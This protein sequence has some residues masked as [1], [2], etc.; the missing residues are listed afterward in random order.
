MEGNSVKTSST[1]WSQVYLCVALTTMA[2]LLLELSLTRIFS[3]IFYYHFAFLAISIAMF[4]LGLGGVFSYVVAGWKIPLFARLGR[5]SAVNSLLTVLAL[6]VIVSRGD[7]LT[8]WDFGLVYVATALP[9]FISGAIVSLAISETIENV[10]RVYFFD[11]LGAAGGCLLLIPL[12]HVFK[13]PSAVIGAA[14]VFAVAAAIWHSMAGSTIGRIAS[15][16]LALV[17]V[18]FFTLNQRRAILGITHAKGQTL[19]NEFF[20]KWNT[21]SRIAIVHLPKEGRDRIVIDADAATD[22]ANKDLDHLSPD[23]VHELLDAG[24]GLP[25]SIRPAAKTLIIGPGGGWDVT[26]ALASGSRDVT[27]VEINPIIAETIMQEKFPHLSRNL[28]K[29]PGVHV[30]VEDGRSF[31]RRSRDRY[32]VLQATLVDTWASTAA[33]AFA[34]SENNL[35][36][37][38]AFRDYLS[39]LTDD[40][41]VTVT[42]WG[43][44]PPRESLRLLS[45]GIEALGQLGETDPASHFI[46]VRQGSTEGWGALDTVLISRRPFSAADLDRARATIARGRLELV[47]LPGESIR[48]PFYDLL[49]SPDPA[50]FQRNYT[51]DISPVSDNRPFFFYTVQARDLWTYLRAA[52]HESADY[53]INKAV[54]LLFRLLL[55][56]L[57]ATAVILVA[58]PLVLGTRL[59]RQR[60]MAGFLLYF[61][62][63]GAGY[64]LIE[65]GLIQK[66][67]LFLGQPIYALTV[68]IFSMLVSSGLGSFASRRLIGKEQGRLIKTLGSVAL[69]AAFLASIVSGLLTALVWLPLA[70]K[71]VL[72]VLLIA[73]LGFVMGMPFPAALARLEEWHAPSVRWAWSLNAAAS[74]LGSVGALV[75]SI[76]LGLVQTLIVGGLLYL[77]ALAVMARVSLPPA[78][79]PKPGA[80]RVVLAQ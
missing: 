31:V 24:M 12:L 35:Y 63:I 53:K 39:H 20:E 3:V 2:T 7:D 70:W 76:Y 75:C 33:G 14:I 77:A 11:L 23:D 32:Q 26:R 30:E 65:V 17:L 68:V 1:P 54:P 69:L 27:A 13:G 57:I 21:F 71:V 55:C 48:N 52:S 36:T 74:V 79:A 10:G 47:Y 34:L 62:F 50:E 51:F 44:D 72:T 19:A 18:A 40:G 45:L 25:Y 16:A 8:F 46:V 42:R 22:I 64:I 67:I 38:D 78:S 66:F 58:P 56:S 29:R 73:P 43:F 41:M 37:T 28:Y 6:V 15:V 9:F 49:H 60:G 5:L 59:P 61:L 80:G 4:G